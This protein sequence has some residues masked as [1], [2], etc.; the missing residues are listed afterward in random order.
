MSKILNSVFL[1]SGTAI[2]SGLIS[3]PISAAKVG[4]Q[5]TCIVIAIS[6]LVAY[7]TSC[8][9]IDLIKSQ[10]QPLSIVELSNC[11]SGKIAKLI[12]MFSL[13]AL[14][15]ALLCAYF[16]G[17]SSIFG[18]FFN[19]SQNIATFIC[20]AIFSILFITKPK[21]FNNLNSI[22]VFVLLILIACA[23]CSMT[24]ATT[25]CT[26][27]IKVSYKTIMP[28]LPIIFTS[29][30]VQNVCPFVVKTMGLADIKAIK[31]VF[32]IG[33]LI[34]AII[35]A[36]WI[37]AT[38][39]RIYV[40]DNELYRNIL[41]GGVDV[42]TLVN[43]LCNSV[44]FK[45]G[46]VALKLLSLFAILTSATGTGIGLISSLK[47]LK[48]CNS[49]C[50]IILCVIGIPT[51]LTMLVQHPFLRIL[52]FGGMIATTFVIFMPVYLNSKISKNSI[53]GALCVIFG[54]LVVIA[55][56]FY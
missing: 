11:I 50:S 43:S 54:I 49:N 24:T 44:N 28:F 53:S 10:G 8:L 37:Y 29:F 56:L 9:T 42:G 46:A 36:I 20:M 25:L 41:N 17:T 35:Y 2:G 5:W 18:S 1:V 19:L 7:K 26:D 40:Y 34:P 45:F 13:Y 38:L 31:K 4:M 55:E 15:L 52:S 39:A 47:E 12:S 32:L 6:L 3:L 22:L 16:A 23:V 48:Y 30:G 21:V 33:L 51:M 14:S 27:E